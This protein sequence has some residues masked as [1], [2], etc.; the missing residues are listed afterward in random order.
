MI[1]IINTTIIIIICNIIILPYKNFI[2]K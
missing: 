1:N 2:S